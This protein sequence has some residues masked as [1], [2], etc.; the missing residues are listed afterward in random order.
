MMK[1]KRYLSVMLVYVMMFT[2]LCTSTAL[3]AEQNDQSVTY[4][5]DTDADVPAIFSRSGG[6]GA[7]K[8]ENGELKITT[9][10]GKTENMKIDISD[11]KGASRKKGIL[12]YSFDYKPEIDGASTT[13]MVGT[14]STSSGHILAALQKTHLVGYTGEKSQAANEWL[15]IDD[16]NSSHRVTLTFDFAKELYTCSVGGKSVSHPFDYFADKTV[17]DVTYNCGKADKFILYLR[18]YHK[19]NYSYYIDNFKAEYTE[20][21]VQENITRCVNFINVINNNGTAEE[22]KEALLDVSALV[23]SYG[24]YNTQIVADDSLGAIEEIQK[25]LYENA[26]YDTSEDNLDTVIPEIMNIIKDDMPMISV[27][28]ANT[29]KELEYSLA[30]YD[31]EYSVDISFADE[32]AEDEKNLF[33]EEILNYRKENGAFASKDDIAEAISDARLS[34]DSY[35]AFAKYEVAHALTLPRVFDEYKNILE[36]DM[37]YIEPEYIN[38]TLFILK[39]MTVNSYMEIPDALKKAYEKAKDN[40]EKFGDIYEYDV[41]HSIAPKVERETT[42]L[43]DEPYFVDMAGFAWAQEAVDYLYD[44]GVLSGKGE[45]VFAPGDK[46]TREE[47][48]KII[49]NAFDIELSDK[50]SGLSDIDEAAWYA[51]YV[52]AAYSCGIVQG[53]SEGYFGVGKNITREDVAVILYRTANIKNIQLEVKTGEDFSDADKISEYAKKPVGILRYNKIINGVGENLFEPKNTTTRAEAAV[54]IYKLLGA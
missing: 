10:A 12:T 36:V 25:I 54:M 23:G 19:D 43:Q 48:V 32:Y 38:Q 27:N 3:V 34:A 11:W 7:V 8:I 30:S 37:S 29:A 20:R 39:T 46:I 1:I 44:N 47:F 51:P 22:F 6:G 53:D 13:I 35:T 45:R 52:N 5:F 16:T 2:L 33:Y 40:K 9:N 18:T 50:K 21:Y 17:N 28:F 24:E 26:P 49:V 14:S 4:N 31:K 15:T 41:E 42:V